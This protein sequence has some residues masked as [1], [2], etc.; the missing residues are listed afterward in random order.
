M[1]IAE[2]VRVD[3]K[4]RI[5][6]PMVVREALNIVE[7]M[8]LVLIADTERREIIVSPIPSME[9]DLYELHVEL[10]DVPG[11]L[12]HVSEKLASFNVDQVTTQC[13]TVKR[14]EVAEC[15]MVID[16]ANAKVDVETLRVELS[17]IPEVQLV[18]IRRMKRG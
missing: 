15:M 1:K 16:M 2:V 6:I 17:K 11:A 7:G 3:S 14:G 12:A 4:G 10:K 9:S 13:T 18:N 5:T 8:N